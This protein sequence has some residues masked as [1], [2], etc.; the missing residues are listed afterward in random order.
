MRFFKETQRFDQW[1]L[2]L[3]NLFAIGLVFF[4]IYLAIESK[5][6]DTVSSKFSVLIPLLIVLLVL[7][8]LYGMRL[9]TEMDEKGI[10]FKFFPL[11][12]N[13]KTITWTEVDK[14]FIRRYNP[15]MEYGGWG[16][17]GIDRKNRAYNVKGNEGIQIW[18]KS[19][20][21]ILIGTQ[22]TAEAQQTINR[23]FRKDEGV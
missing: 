16:Y 19:G 8:F 1:W 12:R 13:F 15:I 7:V 21:K 18:L 3:L 9:E 17:R 10:H 23:Y 6:L 22:K 5:G 11:R 20:E 2:H 14:C 4:P